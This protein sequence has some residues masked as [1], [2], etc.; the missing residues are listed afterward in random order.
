MLR[1][2]CLSDSIN[3]HIERYDLVYIEFIWSVK[4]TGLKEEKN[5]KTDGADKTEKR[6]RVKIHRKH[7]ASF[8]YFYLFLDFRLSNYKEKK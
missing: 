3:L 2:I 1:N 7:I 4:F 6:S 8:I 5:S